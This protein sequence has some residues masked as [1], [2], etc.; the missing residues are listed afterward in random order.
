MSSIGVCL[1]SGMNLSMMKAKVYS[2]ASKGKPS[3]YEVQI[4]MV[5]GSG[6]DGALQLS[7]KDKAV[8]KSVVV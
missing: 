2:P 4:S 6:R 1:Y 8:C 3:E 7:H 5:C